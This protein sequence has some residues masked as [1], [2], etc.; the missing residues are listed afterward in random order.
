[1]AKKYYAVRSGK[2]GVSGIYLTWEECRAQ[3]EGVPGVKYKGFPS[4]EE[5]EAF[6]HEE[7]PPAGTAAK[8]KKK[9]E[10]VPPEP[11]KAGAAVAYVDGSYRKETGEYSCGAVLFYDGVRKD[12][13]QK[14]ADPELA[15]MHNVAGEIMGA[16]VVIRYCIEQHIPAVEIY[17]DYRGVGKWGMGQWKTNR[18]GTARYAAFCREAMKQIKLSFIEV[19]GHSGDYWN[20][21]ADHLAKAALGII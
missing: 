15:D 9:E 14:A 1:M 10:T 20:D 12:F 16:E 21:E 19:K 18:P 7:A 6:L 3:V 11:Y 17:H 5:A 8:T 2:D 13:S 4:I